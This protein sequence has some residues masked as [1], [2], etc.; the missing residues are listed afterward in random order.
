MK[1]HILLFNLMMVLI[2]TTASAQDM[3]P[4]RQ[5]T[6]GSE[7]IG[8]PSWS[9]DSRSV[10]Y[11]VTVM[12]DT[13]GHNGL[14]TIS[15]DTK[16][17]KMIFSGIAEHPK[18]S[19]DGKQI[20]FD[21]DYGQNIKIIDAGGGEARSFLP[22]TV[23]IEN[24]GLPCW[25]PDGSSIAFVERK[26]LSLSTWNFRTGALQ[27]LFSESGKVPLPGGWWNDG[28]SIIIALMD[29][30]TRESVIMRIYTDG[31]EPEQIPCGHSGFYR[32]L[33]L[34]PDSS[35]LIFAAMEENYLGFF[36]MS[37]AGG[38]YLP[39]TISDGHNEG[40]VWSPDGR[41]IAFSSGRSGTG[42]VWIM[43]INAERVKK[44]LQNFR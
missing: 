21:A 14:W 12:N 25:S 38:K 28:K 41:K 5:L 33:A 31:R 29:L 40:P 30:K 22:D 35:L 20:V 10:L 24:G 18:W 26:Y 23:M 19:P 3:F 34:S 42:N 17:K 4:V 9:P 16:E 27:S 15:V 13:M 7:R 1:T 36:I 8:F 44:E 11:Q 43:D 6:S 2:I 37:S 32:Y 39:L